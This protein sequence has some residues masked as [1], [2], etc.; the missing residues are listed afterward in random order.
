M[1]TQI[2]V[3]LSKLKIDPANV[4]GE[5]ELEPSFLAS[6]ATK[7]IIQPLTVR[8]NGEGYLVTD[9]GKRLQALQDLAKR[10]RFGGDHMVPVVV[11]DDSDIEAA[12]TSLTANFVRSDM[13]PADQYEA[14]AK[15]QS[16]G[17]TR[18]EIKKRYGLSTKQVDQVLALGALSPAVRKAWKTD[19]I[20]EDAVQAFTL[21]P[22]H[23]RQDAILKKLGKWPN[24][25]QVRSA[26][27]GEDREY[28]KLMIFVTPAAYEAAGGT[29]IKNL[30][31][32]NNEAASHVSD[33][34]LLMR[35]AEEKMRAECDK[36]VADGWGWAEID[37]NN[38]RYQ[39]D[40]LDRGGGKPK[41]T[42][43]PNCGCLLYIDHKGAL[44]VEKWFSKTKPEAA[45]DK[46]K[47]TKAG[48][49]AQAAAVAKAPSVISNALRER[50]KKQLLKATQKAL[51]EVTESGG[52]DLALAKIVAG[53]IEPDRPNY[54]PRKVLDG[55]AAVRENIGHKFMLAAVLKNFDAKDYF[56]SAPNGFV[57]AA[58][59]EAGFSEDQ[60]KTANKTKAEIWKFA[61][62]HVPA[63]GWLPKELRGPYYTGPAKAAP[64]PAAK[65]KAAKKKA[66]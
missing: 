41:A 31:A 9:G 36:L 32:Q 23:A 13:H 52:L 8:K 54:M 2:E 44:V 24:R 4:R 55:L 6:I 5:G 26:I 63:T 46:A 34:A 3:Q 40:R 42:D 53:Q 35:L 18:D 47:A 48:A 17:M 7:G 57:I 27:V 58:I 65:A 62:A 14:F 45:A 28:G 15:L 51:L 22:D 10:G 43:K 38:R 50:L 64:K 30:F 59:K 19:K 66:R 60:A 12:D 49:G 25:W 11:R 33:S 29:I 20:R 37:D 39:M 1:Q 56:S 16:G 61:Q 21:E